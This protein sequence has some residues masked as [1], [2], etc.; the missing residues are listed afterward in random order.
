MGKKDGEVDKSISFQ[1]WRLESCPQTQ[2]IEESHWLQQSL[3][4]AIGAEI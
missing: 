2:M 4:H 1:D 3:F